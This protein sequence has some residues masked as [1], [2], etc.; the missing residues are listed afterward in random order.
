MAK[1]NDT[2]KEKRYGRDE[3][4]RKAPNRNPGDYVRRNASSRNDDERRYAEPKTLVGESVQNVIND[5][6]QLSSSVIEEQIRAGQA[7]ASRMRDNFSGSDKL[8][9]E[10]SNMVNSLAAATKDI[11]NAWVEL[12]SIIITAIGTKPPPGGRP[13]PTGPNPPPTR[14]WSGSS[15]GAQT[16]CHLTPADPQS[17]AEPPEIA[18]TGS[19]A[20]NVTLDLRPPATRFVPVVHP[21]L[22]SDLK[23]RIDDAKFS[24]NA[25]KKLVLTV[26]IPRGQPPGTYTG[27]VVDS[28]TSKSG[29]TVSV[30]VGD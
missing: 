2:K 9:G 29:G 25:Q 10:M 22:T 26:N 14:T 23:N 19:G 13:T 28:T 1:G 24:L 15:G 12:I 8:N 30:T 4:E 11:G 21:L 17:Q 5:M 16:T 7:A 3:P 20:K 6:V 18:V 27:A